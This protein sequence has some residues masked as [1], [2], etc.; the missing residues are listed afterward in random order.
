MRHLA[1]TLEKPLARRFV[2]GL[3]IALAITFTLLPFI[4]FLRSGT[5]MDYRTWFDA[6]QMVLRHRE[7]YPH[8]SAFPFMYPPT[9]ALLLAGAAATGKPAM[10]LILA[11]LNTVAWIFCIKFTLA[12]ATD[13]P[14]RFGTMVALISNAVVIVFI[15]SSYHLGQPSLVLLALMLGAFACLRCDREIL[16]GVLIAVAA[17]IKAFPVLA[18]I[19][20]L[21]RRYWIASASLILGLVFL[22]FLLPLPIRGLQQTITDFREWQRGMLRYDQA[23]IAQRPA[24]SYSWKNQSIWGLSNRLLRRVSAEDEGK[25]VTYANFANLA[26]GQVN[27]VIMTIALFFGMSFVAVMPRVRYAQAGP[28]EFGGL[29]ILILIFAPLAFGYLFSWLMLPLAS[30]TNIFLCREHSKGVLPMFLTATVLLAVTAAAPRVMQI[31]G[32]VFFAAL[33]LYVATAAELWR[34]KHARNSVVR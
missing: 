10:I 20:L 8:S 22:L 29:L 2:L 31:Y 25:P 4:R 32:S 5:D 24:R 21:Y 18:I 9:C 14:R 1:E 19:Y 33:A 28:L 11:L 12:L 30:L 17:G 6:G 13:Q 7:I 16:A 23:G 15:W 3:F 27:A 26:F 34:A